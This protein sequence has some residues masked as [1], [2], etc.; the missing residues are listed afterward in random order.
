MANDNMAFALRLKYL[1]KRAGLTQEQLA[2]KLGYSTHTTIFKIESGK[3]DVSITQIPAYCKALGCTP[4]ELL[5]LRPEGDYLVEDDPEASTLFEKMQ[6]LPAAQR[7]QIEKT[8]EL[9]IKGYKKE[10]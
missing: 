5:G 2:R 8:V 7:K 6:T 10:E 1:R 3:S 9:L 4:L